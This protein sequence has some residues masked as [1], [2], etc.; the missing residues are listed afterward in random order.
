ME[1][2]GF[3]SNPLAKISTVALD[4]GTKATETVFVVFSKAADNAQTIA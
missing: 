3:L 2:L 1:P 4:P